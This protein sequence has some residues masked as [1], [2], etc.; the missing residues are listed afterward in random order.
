MRVFGGNRQGHHLP[1]SET[2]APVLDGRLHSPAIRYGPRNVAL[3]P[4]G[5]G[6]YAVRIIRGP[7]LNGGSHAG[8]KPEKVL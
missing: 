8:S 1:P 7:C 3:S 2:A 4:F 5:V 6:G